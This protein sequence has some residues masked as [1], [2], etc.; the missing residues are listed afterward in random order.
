MLKRQNR[1]SSLM[2]IRTGEKDAQSL[3]VQGLET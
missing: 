1:V 2:L 3:G